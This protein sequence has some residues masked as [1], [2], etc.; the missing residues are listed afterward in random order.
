M[1]CFSEPYTRSNQNKYDLKN[2]SSNLSSFKSKTDKLD[3]DKLASVPVDFKKLS[4]VLDYDVPK[5]TAY[6]KLVKNV[7]V[8][9]TSGLAKKQIM[10]IRS[11]QLKQKYLILL[12]QL[13]LLNLMMLKIR[14]KTLVL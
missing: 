4:D 14:C 9:D 6:D 2:V 8:I 3:V 13:L 11:I 5:K 10:M 7:I 1:S 12:A